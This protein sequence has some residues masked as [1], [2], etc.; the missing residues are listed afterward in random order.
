MIVALLTVLFIVI[1]FGLGTW[2]WLI[3]TSE[4]CKRG[5]LVMRANKNEIWIGN[6]ELIKKI[7]G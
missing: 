6:L 4:L 1:G 2:F 5:D 3:V 7:K